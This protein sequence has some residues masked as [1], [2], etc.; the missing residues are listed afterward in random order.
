MFLYLHHKH[1]INTTM[2][3]QKLLN[4]MPGFMELHSNWKE[5]EYEYE[6]LKVELFDGAR[7]R[8]IP[9]KKDMTDKQLQQETRYSQLQGLFF[10]CFRLELWI[11]PL[12]N[13]KDNSNPLYRESIK[14]ILQKNGYPTI[15]HRAV[16]AYMRKLYSNLEHLSPGRFK[17][18][19]VNAA[20]FLY[21]MGDVYA[22]SLAQSYNL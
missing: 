6:C 14:T 8:V 20:Q 13:N 2:D 17:N 5:L 4:E 16:E 12:T 9:N 21:R 3:K 18:E 7:F 11:N 22:E 19:V 10:P 15:D 1:K